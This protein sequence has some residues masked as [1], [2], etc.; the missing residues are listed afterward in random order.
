M[1]KEVYEASKRHLTQTIS[2]QHI[3][4]AEEVTMGKLKEL[5]DI[6]VRQGGDEGVSASARLGLEDGG[7]LRL[8]RSFGEGE[9]A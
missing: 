9:G 3:R 8:S 1:E 6:F 4:R 7:L 2:H 5:E